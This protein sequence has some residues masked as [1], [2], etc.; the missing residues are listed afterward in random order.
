MGIYTVFGTDWSFALG[1]GSGM[2]GGAFTWHITS[3]YWVRKTGMKAHLE[4][5]R[6]R[7]MRV[8]AALALPSMKGEYFFWSSIAVDLYFMSKK[9]KSFILPPLKINIVWVWVF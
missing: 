3:R 7:P 9:S 2:L 1:S 4:R 8:W 5:V 6:Q